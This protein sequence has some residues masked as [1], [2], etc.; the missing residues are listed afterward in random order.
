MDRLFNMDNGLF[1]ALSRLADLIILNLIFLLCCIPVFTIGAAWTA[2]YYMTLKMVRN[3][4]TYILRGF[5]KSFKQNFKQATLIWLVLL[6]FMSIL[7]VDF[8]IMNAMEGSLMTALRM[9]LLMIATLTA[10]LLQYLFPVLS[11]F[12]NTSLNTVRNAA[13]MSIRHLPQTL[14][15]LVV[16]VAAVF[17]TLLNGYTLTYGLLIWLMCGCSLIALF[18]SWFLVRIFDKYVPEETEESAPKETTFDGSAFKNLG[19]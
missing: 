4:E 9:G 12:Y 17:V 7:F 14:V 19:H 18:N 16:S 5:F 11:R 10:I 2:L 13:L 3:E 6:V 1:R 15:M 8:R